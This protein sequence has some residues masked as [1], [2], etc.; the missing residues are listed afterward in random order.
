MHVWM[1]RAVGMETA[2][3]RVRYRGM[4]RNH[5]HLHLLCSAFNLRKAVALL[6]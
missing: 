1:D 5:I 3:A 2:Y 6:G 4:L